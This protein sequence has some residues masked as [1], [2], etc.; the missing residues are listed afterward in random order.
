MEKGN[1]LPEYTG[2]GFF[3][4]LRSRGY[5]EGGEGHRTAMVSPAKFPSPRK[6]PQENPQEFERLSWAVMEMKLFKKKEKQ[7]Q[8][9]GK[10]DLTKQPKDPSSLQLPEGPKSATTSEQTCFASLW[11]PGSLGWGIP[12][13]QVQR[14]CVLRIACNSKPFS[15]EPGPAPQG[16][17]R[18]GVPSC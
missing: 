1:F 18:A 7:K 9:R 6:A 10:K 15:R 13:A 4:S 16:Q 11:V 2:A 12:A 8:K 5:G 17:G 3:P 14:L